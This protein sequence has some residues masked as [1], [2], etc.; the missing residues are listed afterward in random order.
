MEVAELHINTPEQPKHVL[1]TV[2]SIQ[3]FQVIIIITITITI[4]IMVTTVIII[5]SVTI[6]MAAVT[7]FLQEVH[8]SDHAFIVVQL[9]TKIVEIVLPLGELIVRVVM[10]RETLNGT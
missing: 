2:A 4:S 8:I 10:V 6:A 1:N 9:V 3:I 7:L 5:I